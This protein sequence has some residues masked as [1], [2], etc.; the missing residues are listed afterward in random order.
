MDT[1]NKSQKSRSK[2]YREWRLK[3]K[4]LAT[5]ATRQDEAQSAISDRLEMLKGEISGSVGGYMAELFEGLEARIM[6]RFDMLVMPGLTPSPF[7][8]RRPEREMTDFERLAE[9]QTSGPP[10]L[11]G[12]RSG[13]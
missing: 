9:E 13:A 4:T 12:P 6:A 3:R 2:Y 11:F 8:P 1:K 5:H 7:E 10:V